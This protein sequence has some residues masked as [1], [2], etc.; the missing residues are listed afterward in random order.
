MV[1]A[2]VWLA[3]RA[4]DQRTQS[5]E[6]RFRLESVDVY[7]LSREIQPVVAQKLV[8]S[9]CLHRLSAAYRSQYMG[10]IVSPTGIIPEKSSPVAYQL[11]RSVGT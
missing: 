2:S 1:N 4:C 7:R 9:A 5:E 3:T 8:P 10:Q 11:V 6:Y